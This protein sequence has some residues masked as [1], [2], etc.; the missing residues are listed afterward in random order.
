M[1]VSIW[2]AEGT[3]PVC[4][5]DFLIVGAGLVGCTAAYFAQQAGRQVTITEMRDIAL[6]ASSRNAG[7]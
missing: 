7:S 6:G 2:Q 4:E 1:T 3:Q 5:V